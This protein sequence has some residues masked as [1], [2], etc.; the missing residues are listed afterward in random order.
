VLIQWNVDLIPQKRKKRSQ[1]ESDRRGPHLFESPLY[2][3]P[4]K[5]KPSVM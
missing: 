4:I 2:P 3:E 5:L 1:G